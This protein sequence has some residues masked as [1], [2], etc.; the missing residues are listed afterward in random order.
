MNTKILLV[1]DDLWLAELYSDILETEKDCQVLRAD[2]ASDAIELL[3][4]NTDVALIILDMFLP[5]HNG[6]E[7]LHEIASYSDTNTIPVIVLSSVYQH[8]FQMSEDRW[9]HYGVVEYL[10]KPKTRPQQLVAAVKKQLAR[11]AR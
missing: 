5:G 7:F 3:D 11:A 10:Y 6:I 1:E 9:R 4:K 8:D 2:S